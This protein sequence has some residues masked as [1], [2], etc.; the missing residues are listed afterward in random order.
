MHKKRIKGKSYFYTSYRNQNG[1]VKTKYLG[2]NEKIAKKKEDNFKGIPSEKT[3]L[4][5]IFLFLLIAGV[6]IFNSDIDLPKILSLTG[7]TVFKISAAPSASGVGIY[8]FTAYYNTS[9]FGYGNYSDSEFDDS[10]GT[11][12]YRWFVDGILNETSTTGQLLLCHFNN[13]YTCEE[14]ETANITQYYTEFNNNSEQINI[15]LNESNSTFAYFN[16]PKNAIVTE[17][18]MNISGYLTSDN[19]E[20]KYDSEVNATYSNPG[21]NPSSESNYPLAGVIGGIGINSWYLLNNT[22]S[23]VAANILSIRH[24][25]THG[26]PSDGNFSYNIKICPSNIISLSQVSQTNK[27]DE[28]CTSS[29]IDL[30]DTVNLSS[31]FSNSAGQWQNFSFKKNVSINF[32]QDINFLLKFE[33]IGG[34]LSTDR[35]WHMYLTD[36]FNN[37]QVPA[38][39]GYNYSSPGDYT[40]QK[41]NQLIQFYFKSRYPEGVEIDVGND[42]TSDF[43]DANLSFDT[44]NTTA[45]FT[46]AINTF[47]NSCSTT[48]CDVPINVSSNSSGMVGLEALR[49]SYDHYDLDSKFSEGIIAN[50]TYTTK[51]NSDNNI[52]NHNGTLDMWVK[53]YWNGNDGNEYTFFTDSDNIIQLNKSSGNNLVFLVDSVSV[54]C[55]ISGWTA[56]DWHLITATWNQG[57]NV[58]LY[59]DGAQC[60][61]GNSPVLISGLGEFIFIGSNSE[62]SS[63]ANITLDELRITGFP[64]KP[65]EINSYFSENRAFF[66]N[67]IFLNSTETQVKKD[68]EIIFE[69]TPSDVSQEGSSVNS[70]ILTIAN[71]IPLIPILNLPSNNSYVSLPYSF[72]WNNVTDYDKE[73]IIYYVL[74]IDDNL[75]FTEPVTYYNGSILETSSPT[76]DSITS[77]NDGNYSWRVLSFD[78]DAN[79]S[80]SEQRTVTIDSSAPDLILTSNHY[81]FLNVS[82]TEDKNV[83]F[84]FNVSESNHL[85]NCTFNINSTANP[86]IN[87]T[88]STIN[89]TENNFTIPLAFGGY[90]WSIN[91]TDMLNNI[92]T[93]GKT[94][95]S[96][97]IHETFEGKGR[98][99]NFSEIADPSNISNL[100]I[101]NPEYGVINFTGTDIDLSTGID[102][103]SYVSISS[104]EIKIDASG[105]PQLNKSA[106]LTL[107]N[108]SMTDIY[109]VKDN[110]NCTECRIIDSSSARYRFSIE[111]GGTYITSGVPIPPTPPPAPTGGS[112]GGGGTKTLTKTESFKLDN[113]EYS[114]DQFVLQMKRN[115][116]AFK[117]IKIKNTGDLI[118]NF[119]IDHNL[120][121]HLTISPK[122]FKLVSDDEKIINADFYAGEPGIHTGKII[123]TTQGVQKVIPVTLEVRSEKVMVDAKLDLLPE[124]LEIDQGNPLKVQITMFNTADTKVPVVVTY[125]LKDLDGNIIAE[126]TETFDILDKKSFIKTF[127]TDGLKSGSYITGMNV[128]YGDSFATSS[129]RFNIKEEIT[130]KRF[131]FEFKWY[132]VIIVLSLFILIMLL[133]LQGKN[134]DK[135][136]RNKRRHLKKY[137]K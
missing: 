38:Y 26:T 10:N 62:N 46:S 120:G 108:L 45:D 7:A 132:Y 25:N 67:E 104:N 15:I 59:I 130:T 68:D 3:W 11:S 107:F 48:Y 49:V 106:N 83:T 17:A 89:Q 47:L 115:A 125:L 124:Y 100:T 79:S 53:P 109:V 85:E 12:I 61:S 66:Q 19:D 105:V 64:K 52:H 42:G 128:R 118:L 36:N 51:Y 96:F 99:S 37:P 21:S 112:G 1:Q 43:N 91:C 97:V 18:F 77:V 13:N 122:N 41:G 33:F 54:N 84:Y 81:T 94:R 2:N 119:D 135:L 50:Y 34:D 98:T 80:F 27:P 63:Q 87:E 6:L 4:P 28:N 133:K 32:N 126:E 56:R 78:L 88:I 86:S 82:S 129:A 111:S 121:S 24:G 76:L 114:A 131:S 23:G 74:Q 40:G 20:L 71:N 55:D 22:P 39:V 44:I 70:S 31:N 90:N 110:A 93:T 57:E 35:Y 95:L 75:A 103:D 16:I 117:K 65:D 73:D 69:F 134:L 116:P 60:D 72:S 58:Y 136:I 113:W 8:N 5:F 29:Y 137:E 30:V 14:E 101:E 102:L 127:N 123:I 9:L 92:N